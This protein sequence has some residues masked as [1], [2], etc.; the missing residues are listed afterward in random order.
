M[1]NHYNILVTLDSGYLR[2]L[3][4]ML[5]SLTENNPTALFDVYILH[6]SLHQEHINRVV[7]LVNETRMTLYPI[8][9][10]DEKID[11]FPTSNRY[12]KE[13]YF[14]L[15]CSRYLPESIDRIL[16]L[17]P[18][19]VT[20]NPINDLYYLPFHDNYFMAC[21]HVFK[22]GQIFNGIRLKIDQ[23]TP[24]FNSG[25]ILINLDLLRRY[26]NSD[27]VYDYIEKNRKRLF[28]P[29]QDVFSAVYGKKTILLD[30]LKFNLGDRYKVLHDIY[31][32]NKAKNITMDWI[33]KNTVIIH[34]YGKN[35]PW[36]PN[37]R[38]TLNQFYHHYSSLIEKRER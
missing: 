9:I 8:T 36:K 23:F 27:T 10:N 19:I 3:C 28:L 25:V 30:S 16:Y 38:G 31:I 22:P 32:G 11:Q 37:Y 18:D 21:S 7:H 24:Y 12:P 17:D 1:D 13:M 15:F 6:Q 29:D 34:Y 35:K 33:K 20:I 14:R 2:P 26:D 4:V 5:K